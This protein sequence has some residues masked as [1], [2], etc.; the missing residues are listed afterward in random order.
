MCFSKIQFE[1]LISRALGIG[2][3]YVNGSEDHDAKSMSIERTFHNLDG[4]S[5]KVKEKLK[6]MSERLH[7]NLI[8]SKV[9]CKTVSIKIKTSSF[10]IL[11]RAKTLN[12]YIDSAEKIL[13]VAL[14]LLLNNCPEEKI[15]LIGNFR[16]LENNF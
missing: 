6:L 7:D 4:K 2:S 12:D 8:E 3:N 10:E 15:R 13:E 5:E 11:T 16:N 9:K 14:E 1:F